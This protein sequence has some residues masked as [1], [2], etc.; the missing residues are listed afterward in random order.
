[1]RR[2]A[3]K[4]NNHNEI[5]DA[6]QKMGCT[7]QDTHQL[8]DDFPDGIAGINGIVNLLVEVKNE[9]GGKLSA[10]QKKFRDHWNGPIAKIS[11]I[12]EVAYIVNGIRR[13]KTMLEMH[14]FLDYVAQRG[15]GA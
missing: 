4:D 10:G 13:M 1:V 8:G 6:F 11:T 5:A 7:W 3:K 2:T 15:A 14:H 12:D 9:D